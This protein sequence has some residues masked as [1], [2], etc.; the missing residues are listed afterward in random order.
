MSIRNHSLAEKDKQSLIHPYTNLH[1]HEKTGPL[2]I[3]R[4][5]GIRVF[6][7]NGK[8]YIE[9]L[10]GL[11][12]ASLGFSELELARVATEQLEKLPYYHGF[13]GKSTRPMIELADKLRDI[14]PI[15]DARIFLANS[16][17]EI[18]DTVVKL[19]WYANNVAGRP[20]KK[21]IVTR[22]RSYHGVTL[23][24][25]SMTGLAPCHGGFD[26]PLERFLKCMCPDYYRD[27]QPDETEEQF[28]DRCA[29]DLEALIVREGADTIAAFFADPVIGG[30]GVVPPPKGYFEKIQKVLTKHDILFVA[31]EVI[32]GFGRTGNMFAS[33]TYDLSPDILT[34]AKALSSSYLPISA[35]AI[36]PKV[37]EKLLAASATYGAFAH[38]FTYSGHP[39]A[40]AVA[41]RTI[42]IYE[43]RN[44]VEQVKETA[45]HFGEGLKGFAECPIVGDVRHVG[46]LGG[47][48]FSPDKSVKAKF[49]SAL[50]AGM[51]CFQRCQH[52]GLIVRPIGDIIAFCPPLIITPSEI[53]EMLLRYEAALSDTRAMLIEKGAI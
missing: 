20:E 37:W 33:E 10:A 29:A 1:Q 14:V 28:S 44:I 35:A 24:T 17:S 51:Y 22:H 52:H 30:G 26:L 11:W 15:D 36:A 50:N 25:A 34:I 5:E 19:I 46:L 41:L 53:D 6:D 38:G 16:G 4:G 27:G 18:N 49:D 43:E 47:V 21:K 45:R 31:D 7:Q 39:V 40:A 42:Q 12:G 3:E 8:E 13:H 9:G 23:A 2:I 48:E 32:C